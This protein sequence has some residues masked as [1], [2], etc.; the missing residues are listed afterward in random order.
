[1]KKKELIELKESVSKLRACVRDLEGNNSV[2]VPLKKPYS[3]KEFS[4]IHNC[5]ILHKVNSV[6]LPLKEMIKLVIDLWI[7][8]M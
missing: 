7:S 2:I 5:T 4:V 6:V 8:S 1:M 3:V